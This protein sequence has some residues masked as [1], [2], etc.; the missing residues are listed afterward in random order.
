MP[1]FSVELHGQHYKMQFE[2]RDWLFRRRPVMK[3]VGFYT[4]R[5]I[6][7]ESEKEAAEQAIER[8]SAEV[9]S[10]A[11]ITEGSRIELSSVEEDEEGFDLY[12]PGGGFTFYTEESD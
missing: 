4:T 5:F 8:V 3:W 12:A 6:E 9:G 1:K 2:K 10:R 7:A 11:E